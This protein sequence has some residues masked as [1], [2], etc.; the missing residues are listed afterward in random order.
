MVYYQKTFTTRITCNS[1]D[2]FSGYIKLIRLVSPLKADADDLRH[3]NLIRRFKRR[4]NGQEDVGT[5]ALFFLRYV[6]AN[7]QTAPLKSS[8]LK[9]SDDKPFF[10]PSFFPNQLFPSFS[11]I[12][13]AET[14]SINSPTH[15]VPL[16]INCVQQV[17]AI[18]QSNLKG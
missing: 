16:R 5:P 14:I 13:T 6:A 2:I 3:V 18:K 7:V 12:T 11:L 10:V 1:I 8:L 4:S 9:V 17:V 15:G